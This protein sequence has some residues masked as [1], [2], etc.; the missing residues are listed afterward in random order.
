MEKVEPCIDLSCFREEE[1]V[2]HRPVHHCQ[3]FILIAGVEECRANHRIRTGEPFPDRIRDPP[4]GSNEFRKRR[5]EYVKEMCITHPILDTR[6]GLSHNQG[7]GTK[8]HMEGIA[9]HGITPWHRSQLRGGGNCALS[10]VGLR[11]HTNRQLQR[12]PLD[13]S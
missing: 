3:I 7:Y 4:S 10:G 9:V 8:Q 11:R 5:D 1:I 12:Q 6:Y 2:H 13:V